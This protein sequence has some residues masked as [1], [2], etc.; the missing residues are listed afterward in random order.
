M[1][2]LVRSTS[3]ENL[4]YTGCTCE[5]HYIIPMLWP[6]PMSVGAIF[7]GINPFTT[8]PLAIFLLLETA[9]LGI[10]H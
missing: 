7:L 2:S 1:D 8:E 5:S 4:A 6:D 9:N 10:I 3:K